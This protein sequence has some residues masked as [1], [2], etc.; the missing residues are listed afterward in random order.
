MQ[1]HHSKL[2]STVLTRVLKGIST[3]HV[4]SAK[5]SFP[6][7]QNNTTVAY[8]DGHLGCDETSLGSVTDC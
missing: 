5:L 4:L 1:F 8:N 3:Y 2:I 6:N 7:D